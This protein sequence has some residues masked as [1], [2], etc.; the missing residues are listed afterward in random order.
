M[1]NMKLFQ[2][3]L[4]VLLFFSWLPTAQAGLFENKG[5]GPSLLIGEIACYG[6]RELQPQYI[7]TFR[8]ILRESLESAEAFSLSTSFRP[9]DK[10]SFSKIHKD[11][12][13]YGPLFQKEYANAVMVRYAE[14]IF[15]RDYFWDENKLKLRKE[16]KGKP[17]RIGTEATELAMRI[18][19]A[20]GA[21]YLF[22]CNLR[23]A[24]IELKHSIFN[25][26]TAFNERP[27]NLKV[28]TEFYLV[29]TRTGLVYEGHIVT[30][31]TGQILNLLGQWGKAM[32]AENLL[33]VMFEVQSKEIVKD[34][35]GKGKR[36]LENR[37]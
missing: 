22:F 17:Y 10:A 18:G 30:S 6:D 36:A 28:E 1:R 2:I 3:L 7:E 15:G 19:E 11:A 14:G 9:E 20:T 16:G 24:N 33:Q 4:A 23:E 37:T 25:A 29:D 35:S 32:T 27:K 34:A 13:A 26:S 8:D 21:N 31:K 5:T 12:I